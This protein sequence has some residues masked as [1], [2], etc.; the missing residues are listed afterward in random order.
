MKLSQLISQ[1][2]AALSEHGDI[3]VCL[4][5]PDEGID[6]DLFKASVTKVRSFGSPSVPRQRWGKDDVHSVFVVA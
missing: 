2:Q 6:D 1:A 3:D 5:C 4:P